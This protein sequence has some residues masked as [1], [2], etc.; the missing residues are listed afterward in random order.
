MKVRLPSPPKPPKVFDKLP[1]YEKQA[2]YEF[3]EKEA[4][5]RVNEEQAQLQKI[6]LQLCCIVLNRAF[7]FGKKRLLL[8]LANWR[9]VY[10]INS[11]ISSAAEQREYLAGEMDRI[12]GKGGYPTEYIDKLE[13]VA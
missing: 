8:F 2:I 13:D 9:E 7:R 10:R 11:K 4:Q 6:W 3:I 1:E 5:R 12:F